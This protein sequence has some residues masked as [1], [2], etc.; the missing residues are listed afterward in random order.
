MNVVS[1]LT[2]TGTHMQL[3][4]DDSTYC[5][6]YLVK[7]IENCRYITQEVVME[8]IDLYNQRRRME[9]DRHSK[10]SSNWLMSRDMLAGIDEQRYIQ[11]RKALMDRVEALPRK[12]GAYR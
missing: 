6:P 3:D 10:V 4:N 12:T 7:L 9:I 2:L 11:E 8:A 1:M 5:Q